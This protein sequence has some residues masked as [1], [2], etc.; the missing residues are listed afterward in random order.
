MFHTIQFT[1]EADEEMRAS[2]HWYEEE[3]P[4]LGDR[5]MQAIDRCLF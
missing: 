1:E 3:S 5:F 2:Y 4:G